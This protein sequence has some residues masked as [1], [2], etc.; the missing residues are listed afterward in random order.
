MEFLKAHQLSIMLFM[1]G[2]CGVLVI[3][4]LMTN[5]LSMRR[6][7]ILAMLEAAAMFLMLFDR[8]A[9]LYRGDPSTRGFWMV[10]ISN[11]LVFFLTL[12]ILHSIT[13]YLFDL[14]RDGNF[15]TPLPKR[16]YICEVLYGLGLGLLITS[17]FTG[18][19]YTFDENNTYVRAPGFIICYLMPILMMLIQC[20]LV[21]QYRKELG[22]RIAFPLILTSVVPIIAAILQFFAYGLSLVNMS[23][24]GMVIILYLFILIDMGE[25][26][27]KAQ[28]HEIELYKREKEA[29]HD[30]FE[31]TAEA[32]ASAIDAKDE[33]THGHSKRVA[34][35]SEQIAREA[36]KTEEER[37]QVYFAALLHDVGK[38]GV[39]DS[40]ITKDGKLTDEEF[41]EIKKHPVYGNHILSRIQQLPY[42]SIGAHY[43]HERY[44]GR[45]YPERLKGEDIPEI[46]RM[47]AVADAYD[48]MTSK[49]SYRDPIPQDQVREELVKGMGTQFDPQFAK[50]MLHLI[51]LDTEYSM[52]ER[53]ACDDA[54]FK[55]GLDCESIG[56]ECSTGIPIFEQT[57]RIRLFSKPMD[58]FGRDSLPSLVLF[59][60]LDGRVHSSEA[61]KKD[62]LY[63]EYGQVRFDGRTVCE[64][65][66]KMESET[67]LHQAPLP[68]AGN[69]GASGNTMRY[70]IEAVRYSDHLM[71]KISDAERMCQIITA[72]PDSTHFSYLSITGEHCLI[73]GI[74]IETDDAKIGPDAI[75]RIAEEISYIRGCPEG[76]IPNIQI[77]RWRSASTRGVPILNEMKLRF[78]AVS[79]PVAR[80]VWHCPFVCIFTSQDGTVEGEGFREFVL[81]RLDGENWESDAQAENN[82]IINR[83]SDFPG[84]NEWKA[85]FKRGLD[86]EVLIRREGR[87][88]TVITEN[89]GVAIKC[90]SRI[91]GEVEDVYVALT[92]DE[93]AI[94]DIHAESK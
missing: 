74:R 53:E 3:L 83:S 37:E 40:I 4:T 9:Y 50:I 88:I 59:D 13:R 47:I 41:A 15:V 35:Y 86:C 19:Y 91:H 30:M 11:F 23:I 6:R 51:D 17:Q 58:G 29:E 5:T 90:I 25:T 28:A 77:D 76:D 66:R 61:K 84:W 60:S 1:S 10:R 44:D 64:A 89:L 21:V 39:P 92:G 32:L 20:S 2:I 16:L 82:V 72:L 56:N 85:T 8:Y 42:L 46:A 18:L 93:C 14:F 26:V 71:L 80:L 57:V 45:G 22:R 12:F 68:P 67:F 33:Y 38:I 81:V 54:A 87:E 27:Q 55:T 63:L 94:T 75:P 24:V 34:A 62:L 52:Q 48:A 36:G 78:H 79:L 7:R 31:Q 70:D 73:R 49:R 43:H 69:G 65:A